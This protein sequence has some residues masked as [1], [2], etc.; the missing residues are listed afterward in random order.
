[1]GSR[2]HQP[3]NRTDSKKCQQRERY[4]CVRFAWPHANRCFAGLPALGSG[5]R[6]LNLHSRHRR[7]K[8]V[9]PAGQRF[10]ISRL[11]DRI[12]QH[13]AHVRNSVVKAM[14]EVDESIG[15]PNLGPKFVASHDITGAV[16]QGRE[17]LERLALE[18]ELYAAFPQFARTNVQ[19]K[20]VEAK[21]ACGWCRSSHSEARK[22]GKPS[23][24]LSPWGLICTGP[25]RLC[26]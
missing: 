11:V 25:Q 14:V 3:Q 13:F 9:S 16:Q 12:A 17:Y 23:T 19:L 1:M 24:I 22:F 6:E 5:P 7:N 26:L 4:R 21:S 15:R 8:P 10:D 18:V 20:G 2:P